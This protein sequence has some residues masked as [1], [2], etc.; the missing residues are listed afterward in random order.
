METLSLDI[1]H[2]YGFGEKVKGQGL[3]VFSSP[4]PIPLFS[5]NRQV[6]VSFPSP[7]PNAPC[8]IPRV[9]TIYVQNLLSCLS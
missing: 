9:L 7:M 4:F 3:K 8:P 2:W 1:A 5:L 6:L